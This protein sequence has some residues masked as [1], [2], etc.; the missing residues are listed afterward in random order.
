MFLCILKLSEGDLDVRSELRRVIQ[1]Y[2]A[3]QAASVLL[4]FVPDLFRRCSTLSLI[5]SVNGALERTQ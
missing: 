4:I 3:K 5:Y 1:K 2:D